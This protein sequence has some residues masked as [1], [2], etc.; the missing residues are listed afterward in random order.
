MS[1]PERALLSVKRLFPRSIYY[2]DL[3][4]HPKDLESIAATDFVLIS[5][6]GGADDGIDLAH[7]AIRLR[8]R[9]KTPFFI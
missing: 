5:G 2:D 1:S 6:H 4:V 7:L 9:L 3:E 8:S